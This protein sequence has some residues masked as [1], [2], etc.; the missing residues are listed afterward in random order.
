M[1]HSPSKYFDFAWNLQIPQI[2]PNFHISHAA[3]LLLHKVTSEFVRPLQVISRSDRE[4]TIP[5][6]MSCNKIFSTGNQR[7]L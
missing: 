2:S 3:C 7:Y 1:Q 6:E 4:Q 5:V